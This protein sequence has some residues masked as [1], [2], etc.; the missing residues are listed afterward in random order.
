ADHAEHDGHN[1]PARHAF[2]KETRGQDRGPDR[3]GELDR[4]HLAD[5]DQRQREEPAKLL[6]AKPPL[7]WISGYRKQKPITL[8]SSM[9]WNTFT[10][11]IASR[12]ATTT[13]SISDSQPAIQRGALGFEGVRFIDENS[14]WKGG[15]W[16]I[17]WSR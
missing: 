1:L 6:I 2:A 15:E 10:S 16:I 14:R 9:S 17:I 13:T 11:R 12:P 5:R 7:R 3:H 4:H 8:R